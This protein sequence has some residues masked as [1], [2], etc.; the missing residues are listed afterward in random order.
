MQI[1]A[2][3]RTIMVFFLRKQMKTLKINNNIQEM[4]KSTLKIF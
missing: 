2:E 4:K 3:D 1:T